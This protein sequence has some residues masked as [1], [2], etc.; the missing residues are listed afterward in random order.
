[1]SALLNQALATLNLQ[2]GQTYRTMVNGHDVEV[3]MLDNDKPAEPTEER[4]QFEDMVMLQPWFAMPEP[5]V[6]R[7]IRVT[8]GRLP[9]PDPPI[10]PPDDE[11]P[12]DERANDED[13]K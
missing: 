10:I 7:T 8:P 13:F 5:T 9:L 11:L 3:R 6:V 1:M 2:P 4:S 12:E